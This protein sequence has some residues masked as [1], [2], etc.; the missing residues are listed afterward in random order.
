[1]SKDWQNY[2]E[3]PFR[4]FLCKVPYRPSLDNATRRA[5]SAW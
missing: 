4:R 3:G 2:L 5:G 1:M